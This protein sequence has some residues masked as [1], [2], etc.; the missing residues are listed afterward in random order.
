[1]NIS[2][3]IFD[4]DGTLVDSAPSIL[5]CMQAVVVEAG[6]EPVL[7]L[8]RNLIGPPLMS[9][10]ARIT[11]LSEANLLEP[12]CD[13]FKSRYDTESLLATRPFPGIDG[14]LH[15]LHACGM[16]LHLATNKRARPTHT[17]LELL[18]WQDMFLSIYT[19]DRMSPGY[20][21]KTAMLEDQLRVNGIDTVCTGY[22][23]DTREDGKA[24][25]AN[26]MRFFAA[27]WGYGDFNAWSGG[28]DW[29]R[30]ATPADLVDALDCRMET[31]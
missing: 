6:Y 29:S 22:V 1:M 14:M 15:S 13:A 9:T 3:L 2:T 28:A 20:A 10:L 17:I 24:T 5:A 30:L 7:P 21:D 16:K 12:L 8:Q 11:G 19:Q 25:A 27:D 18:G 4:L 31:E 26:R 23:G